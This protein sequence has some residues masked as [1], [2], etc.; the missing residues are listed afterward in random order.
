MSR[1]TPKNLGASVYARL[2]AQAR[3]SGQEFQLLLMR[4]GL[5]RLLY[6][7][8]QSEHR[9]EFVMKGAMMFVVWAGQPY[10]ATHLK[11]RGEEQIAWMQRCLRAQE[12][13]VLGL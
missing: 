11:D 10:R 3:Q 9:D 4:Y 12:S 1:E 6:R 13:I 8:S 7:L 2:L 5:E